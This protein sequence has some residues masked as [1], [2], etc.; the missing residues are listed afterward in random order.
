MQMKSYTQKLSIYILSEPT[1]VL[2][3]TGKMVLQIIFQCYSGKFSFSH[4][5]QFYFFVWLFLT[6]L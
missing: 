4:K 5:R 3:G 2:Q 6:F 1:Q